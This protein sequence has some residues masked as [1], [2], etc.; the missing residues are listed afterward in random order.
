MT[1]IDRIIIHAST[2]FS[3]TEGGAL[4]RNSVPFKSRG[5]KAILGICEGFIH[6][7]S[8]YRLINYR[9]S[10][11]AK[12]VSFSVHRL[13]FYLYNHY[14]PQEVDH[15]DRNRKNNH[16]SNLR[17]ATRVENQ[18]NISSAKN[19]T[20]KYLGVSKYSCNSNYSNNGKWVAQIRDNGKKKHLG[21]FTD[22]V[23]AAKA[24]NLETIKRD[25]NFHNI[26]IITK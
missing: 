7:G 1:N 24:Y 23:D 15:E 17:A 10:R 18:R 3:I 2:H 20:S 25:P 26:N 14:L 5:R 21:Y 11:H 8:G 6:K 12:Q 13:V 9:E 22:E 16:P 19:S 4:S